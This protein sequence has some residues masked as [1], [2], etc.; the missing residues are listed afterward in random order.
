MYTID[1]ID[2]VL[3]VYVFKFTEGHLILLKC[4]PCG[5]NQSLHALTRVISM[6]ES[7]RSY[8]RVFRLGCA[9]HYKGFELSYEQE[10]LNKSHDC[11]NM[12]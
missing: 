4:L 8:V 10:K 2:Y 7:I 5:Y 6:F 3:C 9:N 12:V 1:I 11:S